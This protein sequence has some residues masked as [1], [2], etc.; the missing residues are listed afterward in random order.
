MNDL[1]EELKQYVAEGSIPFR[2]AL[3]IARMELSSKDRRMLQEEMENG[4]I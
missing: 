1:P 4:G 3:K 2:Q